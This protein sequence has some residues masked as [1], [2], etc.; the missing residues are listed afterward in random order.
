MLSTELF[1]TLLRPPELFLNP[2]QRYIFECVHEYD[3]VKETGQNSIVTDDNE[4]AVSWE[5]GRYDI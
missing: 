5:N 2:E 3:G 4:T 1:F